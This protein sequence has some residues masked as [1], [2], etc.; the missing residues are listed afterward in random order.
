MTNTTT[1]PFTPKLVAGVAMILAGILFLLQE[2]GIARIG[3]ILQLWPIVLIVIGGLKIWER[4]F[5]SVFVGAVLAFVGTGI[6]LDNFGQMSFHV[7]RLWPLIV[8]YIGI[9]VIRQSMPGMKVGNLPTQGSSGTRDSLA[10]TAAF[11][12]GDRRIVTND[13]TGG[14]VNVVFGGFDIDLTQSEMQT[15]SAAVD[16][17]VMWGGVDL[18]VPPGWNVRL[19]VLPLFAGAEDKTTHPPAGQEGVKELI[20]TGV[21][22][23]G[24]VEV[25]N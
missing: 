22:I 24:G 3:S 5:D 15:E 14:S 6:L 13:F 25:K 19:Q 8:I 23:F 21:A 10:E 18:R 17:F 7:F 4:R 2:M 16:L 1:R 12:G 20:V 9:R 11:G